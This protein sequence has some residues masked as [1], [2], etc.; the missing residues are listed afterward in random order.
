M[1]RLSWGGLAAFVPPAPPP[2]GWR[3]RWAAWGVF[4]GA[5]LLSES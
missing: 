5:E 4:F 1:A 2:L 3:A